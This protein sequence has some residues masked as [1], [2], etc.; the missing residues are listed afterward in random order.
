M[1]DTRPDHVLHDGP[2]SPGVTHGVV[3]H[4]QPDTGAADDEDR[5]LLAQ[6]HPTARD[7]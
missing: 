6:L 1:L 4:R 5:A 7:R 2:V 3:V